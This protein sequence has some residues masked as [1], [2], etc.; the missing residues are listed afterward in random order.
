MSQA[1]LLL[2]VP[3]VAKTLGFPASGSTTNHMQFNGDKLTASHSFLHSVVSPGQN[4]T[5]NINTKVNKQLNNKF[6][7]E[8]TSSSNYFKKIKQTKKY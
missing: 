4:I 6:R 7:P 3:V 1:G 5:P 2:R 8:K